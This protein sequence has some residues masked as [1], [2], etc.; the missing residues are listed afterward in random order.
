MGRKCSRGPIG[1][2]D[3]LAG[4]PGVF[5]LIN[6]HGARQNLDLM[7]KQIA[8]DGA[9]QEQRIEEDA[10]TERQF[11][12]GDLAV[13]EGDGL[14]EIGGRD[15]VLEN[16]SDIAQAQS[17]MVDLESRQVVGLGEN[18]FPRTVLASSIFHE[19]KHRDVQDQRGQADNQKGFDR[20]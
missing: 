7:P 1:Q 13:V 9:G 3:F 2:K 4:P 14:R 15:G 18:E 6:R 8:G 5:G 12:W 17:G 10:F 16:D 20:K 11:D 19:G